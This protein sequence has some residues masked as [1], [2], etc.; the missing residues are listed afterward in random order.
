MLTAGRAKSVRC[1]SVIASPFGAKVIL[2]SVCPSPP[3]PGRERRKPSRS[4]TVRTQPF[5]A[6]SEAA[7]MADNPP[8]GHLKWRDDADDRHM[9]AAVEWIYG[10]GS[11]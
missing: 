11:L 10:T 9:A 1:Q 3:T 4:P 7:R 5:G 2:P 8:G 6:L